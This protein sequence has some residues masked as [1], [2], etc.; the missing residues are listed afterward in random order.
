MINRKLCVGLFILGAMGH[1]DAEEVAKHKDIQYLAKVLVKK[2]FTIKNGTTENRLWQNQSYVFEKIKK[3]PKKR[4]EFLKKGAKAIEDKI[5]IS[6]SWNTHSDIANRAWIKSADSFPSTNAITVNQLILALLRKE[7]DTM[8]WYGFN[9]KKL[10]KYAKSTNQQTH[11][12]SSSRVA[13]ALLE[14]L[15]SEIAYYYNNKEKVA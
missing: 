11:I 15:D 6:N 1:Y 14:E 8:K 3:N 9:H 13:T 7:P 4:D 12:F 5:L 10:D 2:H